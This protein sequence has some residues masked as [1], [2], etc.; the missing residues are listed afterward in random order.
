MPA[1]TQRLVVSPATPGIRIVESSG[2]AVA[3]TLAWIARSKAWLTKLHWDAWSMPW[4]AISGRALNALLREKRGLTYGVNGSAGQPTPW[5]WA[6][7]CADHHETCRWT[8]LVRAVRAIEDLLAG[9]RQDAPKPNAEI[10]AFRRQER[11]RL[12]R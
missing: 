7:E 10:E 6:N 12:S 11:Q 3:V 8:R 5:Y 1:L 2:D 4:P 9:L